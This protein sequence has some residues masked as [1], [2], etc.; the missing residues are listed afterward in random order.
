MPRR[1]DAVND[2]WMCDAGRLS[3]REIGVPGPAA[4]AARQRGD[5]SLVEA[6]FDEAVE[7]RG[8]R[9]RSG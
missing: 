9:L 6:D 8:D 4:S 2:T 1:N 7:S 5:G 3:Y